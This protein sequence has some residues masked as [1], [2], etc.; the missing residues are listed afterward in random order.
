VSVLISLPSAK[1]ICWQAT[2]K[3]NDSTLLVGTAKADFFSPRLRCQASR[4]GARMTS[5]RVAGIEQLMLGGDVPV[6]VFSDPD[7]NPDLEPIPANSAIEI[8]LKNVKADPVVVR[9]D[10]FEGAV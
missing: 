1:L 9:I 6:E 8:E 4:F 2:I 5:L 3:P 10:L 7:E